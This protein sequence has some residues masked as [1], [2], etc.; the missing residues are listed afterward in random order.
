MKEFKVGMRVKAITLVDDIDLIGWIGMVVEV[1]EK[2]I[3][4]QF[5]K[6]INKVDIEGK[7]I[8]HDC[9][10]HGKEGYCR[11]G[12]KEEFEIIGNG[13]NCNVCMSYYNRR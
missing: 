6:I 13:C 7:P 2:D 10:G 9:N 1:K 3:G 5:D 4:V 12:S 8:G 11:Y